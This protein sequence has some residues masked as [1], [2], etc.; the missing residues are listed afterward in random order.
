LTC[1]IQFGHLDIYR[2]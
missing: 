1:L 2:F